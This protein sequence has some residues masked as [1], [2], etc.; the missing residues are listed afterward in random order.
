MKVMYC[1]KFIE[2]NLK[3][4]SEYEISV[5][6]YSQKYSHWDIFTEIIIIF[7]HIKVE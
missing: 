6:I 2:G 5:Y 1:L 4:D 7:L 3:C